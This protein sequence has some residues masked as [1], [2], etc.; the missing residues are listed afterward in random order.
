MTGLSPLQV[1]LSLLVLLGAAALI[2]SVIASSRVMKKLPAKE[3]RPWEVLRALMIG[4]AFAYVGFAAAMTS[5]VT[6]AL[7]P[8]IAAAVFFFGALFVLLVTRV[9]SRTLSALASR[10]DEAVN[11]AIMLAEANRQ[12][13]Q[14]V[15]ELQATNNALQRSNAELEEF[16][17]VASH[18]LQE[19]LRKIRAFGQMLLDDHGASLGEQGG[20]YLGRMLKASHR[21]S[22]LIDSLLAFSRVSRKE[23]PVQQ[24]DLEQVVKE[25]CEDLSDRVN[26]SGGSVHIKGKLPTIAARPL[27]MRQLFQN[28]I[29]NALKFQ[30]ERTLPEVVISARSVRAGVELSVADNGI[31]FEPKYAEKIFRVFQR[32]HGRT[33]YEGS[34]VGLS[35]CQKI[36]QAHGGTIVAEGRP[37]VGATFRVTLPSH[38]K[39]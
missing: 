21:M 4:F 29:A 11:T 3:A 8:V 22:T 15:T 19:P 23:E 38:H 27:Q 10:T 36:A 6:V 7:L 9:S 25:V 5:P 30:R 20:D 37:N 34:G 18:D 14:T 2:Y 32:L 31:G 24:V 12:I 16:A 17:S 1:V 39:L 28:L 26:R 13:G 33:E 35:I